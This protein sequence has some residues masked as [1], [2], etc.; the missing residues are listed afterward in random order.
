M[1]YIEYV[2]HFIEKQNLIKYFKFSHF[3]IVKIIWEIPKAQLT[4]EELNVHE[5]AMQY[6]KMRKIFSSKFAL[7]R[8]VLNKIY[9]I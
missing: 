7:E 1:V 3:C 2:D 9:N 6:R 4:I 8:Q 5:K